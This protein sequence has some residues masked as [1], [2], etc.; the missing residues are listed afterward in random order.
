MKIFNCAVAAVALGAMLSTAVAGTPGHQVKTDGKTLVKGKKLTAPVCS[1]CKMTLSTKK[2]KMAS[3]PV[4]IKGKTYYCCA[5][6]GAH[7]ASK[8]TKKTAPAV[9]T[10]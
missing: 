10:S 7:K 6:C 4:K 8:T 9:K 5:A 1:K 2:T 3:V